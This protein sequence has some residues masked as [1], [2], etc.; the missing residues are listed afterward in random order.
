MKLTRLHN[1]SD[2]HFQTKITEYFNKN[3]F[4][5]FVQNKKHDLQYDKDI[6]EHVFSQTKKYKLNYH[7]IQP[8]R[9]RERE[10]DRFKKPQ[11]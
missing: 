1:N 6:L 3:G 9:E 10:R 8:Q 2:S 11:T 5:I 4:K 7:T